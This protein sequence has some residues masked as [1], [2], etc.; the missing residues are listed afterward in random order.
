MPSLV[1]LEPKLIWHINVFF[2]Q[3]LGAQCLSSPTDTIAFR[4]AL[5]NP[6][7]AK[8]FQCFL[9]LRGELL[10]NGVLFWQEVQ[11]YKVWWAKGARAAVCK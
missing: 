6:V 9:S 2:W 7:T 1:L 5:L 4:Q 8:E 3:H 11:K 10:E